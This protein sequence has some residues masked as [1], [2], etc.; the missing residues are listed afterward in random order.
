MATAK[1]KVM[2][3]YPKAH[4][5]KHVRQTVKTAYW[6]VWDARLDGKRIGEGSTQAEAWKN[7]LEKHKARQADSEANS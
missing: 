6:L 5:T 2:E 4:A 1:D 3:A 7:A